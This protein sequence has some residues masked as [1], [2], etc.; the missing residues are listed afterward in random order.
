[1]LSGFFFKSFLSDETHWFHLIT[2]YNNIKQ[3]YFI[4]DFFKNLRTAKLLELTVSTEILT[5][6]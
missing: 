5:D 6:I 4:K 3:S 2:Q 1:M